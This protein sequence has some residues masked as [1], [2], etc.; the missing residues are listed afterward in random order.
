MNEKKEYLYM[1]DGGNGV[2]PDIT[3]EMEQIIKSIDEKVKEKYP[4]LIM[5]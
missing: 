3:P 4:D 2:T 1:D 5:D